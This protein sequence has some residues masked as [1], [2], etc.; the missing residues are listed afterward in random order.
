LIGSKS[1]IDE[2]HRTRKV[3]GGGMRQIGGLAGACMHALD[4]ELPRMNED[5]FHAQELALVLKQI[6][7]V[8]SIEPVET[9]IVIFS[10]EEHVSAE[11]FVGWAEEQGIACFP[12][13]GQ[14]VRFVTH[15]DVTAEQIKRAG[16]L[17]KH[18]PF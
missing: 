11:Q 17:L 15:R 9:N 6:E 18:A 1:F 12:F 2:S 3:M 16:T 4:H 13:G 5:H 10:L 8:A 7:C 14:K